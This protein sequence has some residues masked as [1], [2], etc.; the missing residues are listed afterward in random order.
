[1]IFYIAKD[2]SCCNYTLHE[3]LGGSIKLKLLTVL[4]PCVFVY[5][6]SD[7]SW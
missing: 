3:T 6:Y 2:I 1:M 7:K 5:Y 4:S